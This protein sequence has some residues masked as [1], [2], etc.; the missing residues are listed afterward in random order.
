MNRQHV[1][2][3]EQQVVDCDRTDLG[4]SGGWPHKAYAYLKSAGGS[5]PTSA[6]PYRGVVC[7]F[8]EFV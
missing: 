2:F 3:S 8:R 1:V 4:C 7:Y 6:Y 5:E